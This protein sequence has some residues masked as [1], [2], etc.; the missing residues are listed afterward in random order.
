MTSRLNFENELSALQK[1]LS[2][3]A[4]YVEKAIDDIFLA[5]ENQDMELANTIMIGDRIVD[6]MEKSIEAR[7]LS[8]IARQQP[9]ARD[10]RVVS[11]TLKVVTDIERIGDHAAD[12]AELT[13]RCE[14]VN[15]YHVAEKMPE[16]IKT[17]KDMVHN[18]VD[19]FI[20]R[21]EKAAEQI[22][23]MDDIADDLFNQ[24]KDSLIASLQEGVITVDNMVDILMID[25]YLEKIADHAVNICEWGIFRETGAMDNVRIL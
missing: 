18:A 6:D 17:A 22:I 19:A 7:C 15:I 12:I 14:E 24:V 9:V 11:A 13:M 1:E 3:M 2:D 16:L 4:M 20:Q 5:L 25:K 21:D 8:L 10:L 23:E